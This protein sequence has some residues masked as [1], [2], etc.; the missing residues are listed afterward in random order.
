MLRR[1]ALLYSA[2]VYRIDQSIAYD[3]Y[4]PAIEACVQSLLY[5]AIRGFCHVSKYYV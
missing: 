2:Y 1:I 5:T 4:Y 3:Y